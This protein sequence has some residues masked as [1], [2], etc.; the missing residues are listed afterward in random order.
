MAEETLNTQITTGELPETAETETIVADVAEVPS[1]QEAQAQEVEAPEPELTLEEQLEAAK[2]ESAR[3]LDGWLRAQAELSNARKRFEKQR[4]ETYAHAT[5][6][7]VKRVLPVIDDFERAINTAPADIDKNGWFEGLLLVYRKLNTV[8][9]NFNV[10]QIETVGHSF[11][12]N[13]HEAIMQEASNEHA[14]GTITREVQKGYK[15]GDR[16]IRP[17]LVYVAE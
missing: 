9:E 7:V 15:L 5:A 14:S 8:L 12:P 16:V 2:T 4:A 13:L 6:E 11:D 17:A 1:D 10:M 3:N